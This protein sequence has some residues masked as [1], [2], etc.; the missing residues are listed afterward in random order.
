MVRPDSVERPATSLGFR[1]ED[2]QHEDDDDREVA[3]TSPTID[4]T[5]EYELP[6]SNSD[7][8]SEEEA[9]QDGA[10]EAEV[11]VKEIVKENVGVIP[12]IE[13]TTEKP[14]RR[15]QRPDT[16]FRDKRNELMEL[17]S[18]LKLLQVLRGREEREFQLDVDPSSTTTAAAAA[19]PPS[20]PPQQEQDAI[21]GNEV[22]EL[23]DERRAELMELR[24]KLQLLEELR[25]REKQESQ[26]D[27][28][29]SSTTIAASP[30][31]E[32]EAAGSDELSGLSEE[33]RAELMEL[34][35]KLML[36]VEV[37]ELEEAP[38][39]APAESSIPVSTAQEKEME[40][41]VEEDEISSDANQEFHKSQSHE[42]ANSEPATVDNDDEILPPSPPPEEPLEE[43]EYHN[44]GDDD[45]LINP[46]S[47]DADEAM[48]FVKAWLLLPADLSALEV[49]YQVANL[50]DTLTF[51]PG[52]VPT[53][54]SLV[55]NDESLL[56][57]S[58]PVPYEINW[59]FLVRLRSVRWRELLRAGA[60]VVDAAD[61]AWL[62]EFLDEMEAPPFAFGDPRE[63]HRHR[64]SRSRNRSKSPRPGTPAPGAGRGGLSRQRSA[65]HQVEA[66]APPLPH[67]EEAVRAMNETLW[68]RHGL[69][70]AAA[71]VQAIY[72]NTVERVAW[73]DDRTVQ[74]LTEL[75]EMEQVLLRLL[76]D[77]TSLDADV[78]ATIEVHGQDY[79]QMAGRIQ[80][81]LP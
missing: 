57:R 70:A 79:A 64:R 7:L 26:Q 20:P 54:H 35:E 37:R 4:T 36:L 23:S 53:K 25:E 42:P 28:A 43:E 8:T 21:D 76:N 69:E 5:K 9:V 29:S 56:V 27:I 81:S 30:Y 13:R 45:G 11:A 60:A 68:T 61:R 65:L 72:D 44:G 77:L 58:Q 22:A 1:P 18:K 40:E 49:L 80:Q 75:E 33:K 48:N 16:L 55:R 32:Q 38:G 74:V 63:H 62:E 73:I 34:R 47:S 50:R 24:S 59:H 31:R 71:T 46:L 51:I 17:R 78:G 39:L 66:A 19:P 14:P 15:Q 41:V 2:D 3:T 10:P 12:V 67:E 6:Q 52:W